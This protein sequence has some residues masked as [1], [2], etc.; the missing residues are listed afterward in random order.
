MVESVLGGFL[1]LKLTDLIDMA[2][3]PILLKEFLLLFSWLTLAEPDQEGWAEVKTGGDEFL[4]DFGF[5]IVGY[6]CDNW[7]LPVKTMYKVFFN[8]KADSMHLELHQIW[9]MMSVQCKHV[10]E[11]RSS[12]IF[13]ALC[14]YY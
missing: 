11:N 14:K 12:L 1:H 4:A 3:D 2:M 13:K 5:K 8:D 6:Y 10:D 9:L 7:S